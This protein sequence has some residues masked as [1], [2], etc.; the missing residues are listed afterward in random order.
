M[1]FGGRGDDLPH[2][3]LLVALDRVLDQVEADQIVPGDIVDLY[4]G[5][6]VPADLR[7]IS[8]KDLFIN[9]A[10]FNRRIVSDRKKS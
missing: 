7:I 4:A 3:G 8:C 6:M 2:A 10:S 9:Q 1:A 5:D